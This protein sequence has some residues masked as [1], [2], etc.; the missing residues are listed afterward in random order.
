M[1]DSILRGGLVYDGKGSPP[2]TADIGIQNQKITH[3]ARCIESP[4]QNIID[5]SQYWVCPGFIDI[6]THYDAEVEIN[7]GL[8]ESVRHGITSIVMGNCSL[9]LTLGE[10][11]VNADLFERVETM[12]ELITLWQQQ[13]HKWPNA[14]AYFQHLNEL[15]LGP[16]IACMVGHSTIR[17]EVMGLKRSLTEKATPQEIRAITQLAQEALAAGCIGISIDMV[18]WHR[19]TGQYPGFSLPSHHASYEEYAALA[20]LCRARDAVFQLTPNP[21]ALFQS[22]WNIFK[23]SYGVVRA[24]LRCTIL[25]AMDMTIDPI[26]WRSA[27]SFATLCNRLFGANMRFQTIPEPFTIYSD[28]PITPLFEEFESG[29]MLNNLKHPKDRKELWQQPHFKEQFKKDWQNLKG[30]TFDGNLDEI[31]V[32]SAPDPNW[33]NQSVT[34]LAKLQHKAPLDF[35]IEALENF[36]EDFRWKHTG[37][38]HRQSIRQKLMKHP[39]VLPGFSDAGAHC[40]NIAYFDSALSLLRQSAQTQFIPIERAIQ[41]ITYEPA[42]W[43]NLHGGLIAEGQTANIVILNPKQ[44]QQPIPE[45]ILYQ[46]QLLKKSQRMVKRDT[47][48]PIESVFIK[49]QRVVQN[50]QPLPGLGKEKL[51]QVLTHS[52]QEMSNTQSYN[53]YRNRINDSQIDHPFQTYWDIFVAKHQNS[54]NIQQHILAFILMYFILGFA[55][56]QQNIWLLLTMPLSQGCGLLGHLFF[57]PSG[58]DQRDTAFSW[59]AL[60]SLHKLFFLVLTQQYQ[61]EIVRVNQQLLAFEKGASC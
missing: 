52:I 20:A 14:N 54:K 17:A 48:S 1:L 35:F 8:S 53:R 7:P 3:I 36:D 56:Q 11:A 43:F 60:V 33:Q 30:R 13:A 42:K 57:E 32:V 58:V 4:A 2:Y 31:F 38:N 55:V 34:M 29:Y 59:R 27:T 16:N 51:G 21:K 26:A 37:A 47:H 19:T 18:H 24:P 15:P 44:L 45:P 5:A 22:I 50:G 9:S 28:G 25:S 10:P 39:Y 61:K 40:R 46:D 6:H 12:P 23:L 41:R 49:G